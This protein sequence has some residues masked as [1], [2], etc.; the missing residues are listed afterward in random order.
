[1]RELKWK[2]GTKEVKLGYNKVKTLPGV[3]TPIV[4]PR[5]ISKQPMSWSSLATYATFEG[6]IDPSSGHPITHDTYLSKFK[7]NSFIQNWMKAITFN[8]LFST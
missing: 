7:N 4:S 5:D 3:P 2:G 1:M 8:L 6:C